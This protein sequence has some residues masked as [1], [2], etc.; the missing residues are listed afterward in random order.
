[1]DH[2]SGL[3]LTLEIRSCKFGVSASIDV[4]FAGICICV[5]V[6]QIMV[7]IQARSHGDFKRITIIKYIQERP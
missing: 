2:R 3:I 6:M 5:V 4:G 1:M 7:C